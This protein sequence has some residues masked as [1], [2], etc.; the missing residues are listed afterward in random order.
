M[1]QSSDMIRQRRL[2]NGFNY[3]KQ[4]WIKDGIIQRC[5]HPE[6]MDCRCYGKAH[7]GEMSLEE[8]TNS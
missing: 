8:E 3:A 4:C 5:D 1:R 7:A 2:I 6:S